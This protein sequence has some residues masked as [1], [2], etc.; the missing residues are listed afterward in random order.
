MLQ[1]AKD[2]ISQAAHA[3]TAPVADVT[4]GSLGMAGAPASSGTPGAVGKEIGVGASTGDVVSGQEAAAPGR[5]VKAE[6]RS[7]AEVI[8]HSYPI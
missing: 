1:R 3:V 4:G 5:G 2:A 8:I 7:F 6:G